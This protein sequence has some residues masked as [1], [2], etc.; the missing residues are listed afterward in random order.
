MLFACLMGGSLVSQI[1]HVMIPVPTVQWVIGGILT[2]F[3]VAGWI[4]WA[5]YYNRYKENCAFALGG[6]VVLTMAAS[7]SVVYLLTYTWD[8]L[9][10]SS[11]PDQC[12]SEADVILTTFILFFLVILYAVVCIFKIIE[13]IA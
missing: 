9:C 5:F 8:L 12:Q 6:P 3:A 7:L 11:S 13:G 4:T 2:V 10:P 1:P